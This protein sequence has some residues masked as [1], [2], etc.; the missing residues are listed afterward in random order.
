MHITVTA[1]LSEQQDRFGVENNCNLSDINHI[2]LSMR[3][4]FRERSFFFLTWTLIKI[5]FNN[6]F[7]E[8]FLRIE[9][10]RGGKCCQ[11]CDTLCYA[12]SFSPGKRHRRC[13]SCALGRNFRSA[14]FGSRVKC[15]SANCAHGGRSTS[16]TLVIALIV[17]HRLFC[18]RRSALYF[19]R[20]DNPS[21]VES[22]ARVRRDKSATDRHVQDVCSYG[23]KKEKK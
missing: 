4:H 6:T 20:C 22:R 17:R 15:F 9:R 7:Q 12:L 3:R 2:L 10:T 23:K 16:I 8:L 19:C 1:F 11:T 13:P 18:R 5:M 14:N 21:R